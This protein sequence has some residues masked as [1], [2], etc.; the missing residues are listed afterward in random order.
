MDSPASPHDQVSRQ[1][2]AERSAPPAAP[3]PIVLRANLRLLAGLGAGLI[4]LGAFLPWIDPAA[5]AML[6]GSRLTPVIQGW[7]SLLIGLIALGVLTLPYNDSARWVSLPAAALGLAA[8]FI[9]VASAI[10]T[11]NALAQII[12]RFPT[13]EASPVNVIGAGT[14]VTV[15]GGVV[16]LI[17]GLSHPSTAL[18]ETRLDFQPGQP[19]FSLLVSSLVIVALVAGLLG[20]WIGSNR[21]PQPSET[22]GAF[23]ADLLSTPVIDAQVTPLG[24]TLAPTSE[25]P[26][27]EPPIPTLPPTVPFIS[28]TPTQTQRAPTSPPPTP[29]PSPTATFG[30]SPLGSATP[31]P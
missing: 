6:G 29:F 14:I 13:G 23:E 11:S 17:A 25:L 7:P 27:T 4:V 3:R 31:T 12:A 28:P 15:A 24:P 8:A 30:S 2:A 19:Q 5:Q 16:C 20:A 26:P 10:A 18:I 9:S 22:P 1:S 21:S